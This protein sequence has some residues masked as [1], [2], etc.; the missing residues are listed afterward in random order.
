[1]RNV[2]H[3]RS[4]LECWLNPQIRFA[5][6][7]NILLD[8][9]AAEDIDAQIAKVLLELGNPEPP[10]RL[11]I[12]RDILA[13]DRAF[14]SSKDTDLLQETVH[15]LRVGTKQVIKRPSLLLD[16]VEKRQLKALWV[17]DRSRILIDAE[18]P[19][20][21]Q[22][23]GEA[24]E[25]GHSLVP[26]HEDMMHGDHKRTLSVACEEHLEAE[27]NYAAGRLLFLR[28]RFDERLRDGPVDFGSVK[29]LS[30]EFENTMTSTLWRIVET[31]KI[32]VFG[33]VSEHPKTASARPGTHPVRYFLRSPEFEGQFPTV[34][35]IE[36]FDGVKQITWG[37]R[38][39]I[40]AGELVLTDIAGIAHVFF[41]EVFFNGYDALTL[42]TYRKKR[43]P[44]I[45]I[46]R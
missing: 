41:V 9:R 22:R 1:M 26:W 5:S 15:R 18:L 16:V 21:K 20:P 23:W 39:P 12:V 8:P 42:G 6:M 31:M 32:P 27:A 17:P 10:L 30:K 19:S 7:Q 3:L 11:E 24:H 33:L 28:D 45:P 40:G 38:G 14:Y 34:T 13:L 4:S 29:G 2:K 44:V 35:H 36:L 25:I 43:A 37:N 46:V